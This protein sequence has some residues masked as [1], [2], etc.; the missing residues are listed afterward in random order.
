MA[1]QEARDLAAPELHR[2]FGPRRRR[3]RA[4]APTEFGAA[5]T[6]LGLPQN[7]VAK[8]F[9]VS[10]RHIRRWQHGNR[11]V[12][13]AVRL[14]INL[15][16][17]GAI[18][19]DQAEGAAGPVSARTN[20]CA[21]PE[22]PASAPV[23]LACA[24]AA[25]HADPGSTTVAAVLALHEASC[26]WPLGDPR[27]SSFRFCGDPVV[28]PPYCQRHHDAAYMPRL[29]EARPGFRLRSLAPPMRKPLVHCPAHAGEKQTD[30][31][32]F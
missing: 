13:R 29:S 30:G 19:I 4:A 10:C 18:S 3:P 23:A 24:E 8:L 26:R 12:P 16:V 7:R 28:E 27:H 9:G 20:G 25:T 2:M 21:R 22:P 14:V 5:F 17:A 15:L 31:S 11:T 1:L 6:T 32:C